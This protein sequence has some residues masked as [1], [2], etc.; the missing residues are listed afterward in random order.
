MPPRS[1]GDVHEVDIRNVLI[2]DSARGVGMQ[3]RTGAGAWTNVRF[4]NVTVRRTK[5]ITG[6][7]WWGK[8]EA[9]W[10][11]SLPEG[12]GTQPLGGIHNVSFTD[13]VFEGE[14]GAIVA[15]RDQ[16]NASG[17]GAGPGISGVVFT[18]V[19]VV[20]GVFG[21]ATGRRGVH[22]FRPVDDGRP[23]PPLVPA[24]VTGYWVEHAAGVI[25]TGG[26]VA[27][28]GPAQP[29]WALGVCVAST[30]DAGIAW[31]GV[32][33]QPAAPLGDVSRPHGPPWSE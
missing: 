27:F 5:A 33:C 20:V 4:T 29:Y 3:Q 22:D 7:N 31:S 9:L 19:S 21:N 12:G 24:N 28:L 8:G 10:L 16:G 18:N 30:P 14:Q 32:A 25:V 15:A 2:T 23:T 13:C 17:A 1:H 11:T 6:A 26:A